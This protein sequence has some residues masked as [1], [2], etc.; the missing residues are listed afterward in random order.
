VVLTSGSWRQ[1]LVTCHTNQPSPPSPNT[2][3]VSLL[4]V[5]I[6]DNSSGCSCRLDDQGGDSHFYM[7]YCLHSSSWEI[8]CL[9]HYNSMMAVRSILV[10]SNHPLQHNPAWRTHVVKRY[11]VVNIWLMANP[12]YHEFFSRVHNSM[13]GSLMVVPKLFP[14]EYGG[15]LIAFRRVLRASLPLIC[16]PLPP[17]PRIT[18]YSPSMQE[19]PYFDFAAPDKFF[20][21]LIGVPKYRNVKMSIISAKSTICTYSSSQP[22]DG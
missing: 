19:P 18:K 7:S 1:I 9:A 4:C 20:S 3:K 14:Q 10:G 13:V 5:T 11:Y 15:T 6:F 12:S 8:M 16:T 21:R 22:V 17:L 2:D